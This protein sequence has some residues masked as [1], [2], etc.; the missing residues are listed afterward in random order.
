MKGIGRAIAVICVFPGLLLAALPR[1]ADAGPV[2]PGHSAM[3]YDPARDGEGWV[4]EILDERKA[5]LYWFTYDEEGDQ[6]WLQAVGEIRQS[7]SGE[8]VSFPE[9]YVT[10]GGRFGPQFD[11]EDVQREVVGEAEMRFASCDKGTFSYSAFDQ[12]QTFDIQRLTKTMGAGCE[13]IH[14]TPG[15]PVRHFAG[16]SGSWFDP[17]HDGEGFA[18]QWLAKGKAILTWYS[19]DPDGNQ[20]WMVGVGYFEDGRIIFPS[21]ESTGGARFGE[22]FDPTD[23]ER[24][25]WGSLV[26]EIGCSAGSANYDSKFP[27]FASGDFNLTRLTQLKQP[28]CPWENPEFT[29]LYDITWTEIPIDRGTARHHNNIQAQSIADDGAVAASLVLSSSE[30]DGYPKL[31]VWRPGAESWEIKERSIDRSSPTISPDGSTIIA[32]EP[33]FPSGEPIRLLSWV[34]EAGWDELPGLTVDRSIMYGT[35]QDLSRVVGEGRDVGADTSQ[36]PWIW[37]REDGQRVLPETPSIR[38]TLPLT[39]SNDGN[40]VVG[41]ETRLPPDGSSFATYAAIRWNGDDP[42]VVMTDPFGADLG[43]PTACDRQCEIVYGAG[44]ATYDS[45]HP[46]PG[47]A[48]Y[49]L[50]SGGFA[51]LGDFADAQEGSSRSYGVHDVTVDGSLAVG[52]YAQVREFEPS[53]AVGFIWTQR[54]GLVSILSLVDKLGIGDDQW[55]TMRAISVSSD[56]SKILLVGWFPDDGGLSQNRAVILTLR[57]RWQQ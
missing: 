56:G 28:D 23:V 44:Q 15:L 29:D 41:I 46:H 48:W 3:W 7:D 16:Q 4:L 54:T 30:G 27:E 18:L 22:A 5:A 38:G 1:F 39:C 32:A 35:S 2:K 17:A 25:D 53:R 14:G 21:L 19:Y 34:K 31:A 26:L 49:R 37:S 10:K 45:E 47:E 57:E 51:Y 20:H 36:H 24:R 43:F 11:P 8:V 40:V 9:L 12:S 6:R 42:P 52:G 33:V 55:R 50:D 13:P